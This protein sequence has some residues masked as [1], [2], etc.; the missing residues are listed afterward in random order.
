[1]VL[2]GKGTQTCPLPHD[3]DGPQTHGAYLLPENTMREEEDQDLWTTDL[4][5]SAQHR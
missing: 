3:M 5:S 1:V 2:A 4:P